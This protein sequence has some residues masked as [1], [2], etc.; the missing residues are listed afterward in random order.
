MRIAVYTSF[1]INYLAKARVLVQT[2][3][4]INPSIDV[5]ALVCDRFPDNINAADE[6]FDQIWMVEDYPAEPIKGWIFRHNIMELSTAVKGWAL[7]RL[8]D[9]GYDYVMYLDPDCWVL[10]DPATIINELPPEASV[11]VVPHT[12]RPADSD[13][14]IRIVETSSLR[15]GI[16]NLGFLIVRNDAN[17]RILAEWWAKRLDKYCVDNFKLG[18]FTDQRWFD[19]AVG[20][21]DF[22]KVI[23]HHGIDVASWN[24][25]QRIVTR[26]G[27][28]YDID[29]D[30]LI[31]YHFSGV[32]PTGVHRWVRDKFA[33]SDPLVA[34]LEFRYERMIALAGQASL[35]KTVPYFDVYEDGAP[36]L[37]AHRLMFRE[38]PDIADRYGDPYRVSTAPNFRGEVGI[39]DE[40]AASVAPVASGSPQPADQAARVPLG[41]IERLAQSLFDADFYRKRSKSGTS[42]AE[43]LWREFVTQSWRRGVHGNRMFDVGHYKLLVGDIDQAAY[44]TPFHHYF[45]VG[46]R[47]GISPSW[48]YDEEYYLQKYPDIRDAIRSG[49]IGSGFEHFSRYGW[50]EGRDGCAFFNERRYLDRYPDV[51]AAVEA[52][53][54]RS[55]EAHYVKHGRKEGRQL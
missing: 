8:L 41:E 54:E 20:Y 51:I 14:E 31:F 27:E 38:R 25:G 28:G 7:T 3:K 4:Q 48:I 22:I 29:G 15:H 45:A 2:I 47:S 42:E 6:P 34:E 43:Q 9:A 37:P 32:G 1:A 13:E 26:R 10:E 16:Y 17:G 55:G 24:V 40:R 21:F 12:T 44:P 11:G 35:E 52:G 18:L 46:H 49:D 5:I 50:A 19:L 33:P 53:R 23:R 30:P 39:I 36:V